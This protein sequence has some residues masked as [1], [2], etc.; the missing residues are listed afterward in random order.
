MQSNIFHALGLHLHQP[1][2]N[3]LD[4][5]R[6]AEYEGIG[7]IHAYDR[8]V[9]YALRYKDI[10]KI[11]IGISGVLLDQLTDHRVIE[12]YRNHVDIEK[13]LED[14]KEADNIEL[15]GMGHFHPV[16]PLIPKAD[17]EEQL[18]YGRDRIIEV[19][20]REP[21]GFWPPEMAFTEE[22]IPSVVKAGY[23]YLLVDSM[24]VKPTKKWD[25]GK[26]DMLT[27]YI[28]EYNNVQIP[29][30]PRN[31]DISNA[32]ESGMDSSWFK[33]EV[34]HKVKENPNQDKPRLV[35]TW[36]DG[37][38]GGWFRQMDE[39]SGFWGHF[40]SPYMDDVRNNEVI[41]P[42]LISDYLKK[43]P[44]VDSAKVETGAWNVGNTSG[45]DFSQWAGSSTQKAGVDELAQVSGQYWELS[46]NEK[47]K[48]DKN[49]QKK[50]AAARKQILEAET[51]CFLFWG[52]DWVPKLYDR[53]KP[54]RQILNEITKS[55]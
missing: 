38:N 50:L 39:N 43:H 14:Y 46:K 13:M 47:V 16:F 40:Y 7:I 11:H 15:L 28:G 1:P 37:E 27:S 9:R 49:L 21:K 5:L 17:W 41:I 52:D 25:D 4:I 54:A 3:M 33:N 36:S 12:A 53:T 51:S 19:F 18:V 48:T 44:P 6:H 22:M 24:H 42:V 23:S 30:I 26:H 34:L 8:I 32:Q 55:L 20:G 29:V 2:G 35:C 31:R 10:A 45:E